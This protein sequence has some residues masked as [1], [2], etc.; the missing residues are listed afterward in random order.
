MRETKAVKRSWIET[1]AKLFL[2]F[3]LLSATPSLLTIQK[4]FANS[5]SAFSASKDLNS[6]TVM[7]FNVE[8]LFDTVHDTGK[9]DQTYLPLELKKRHPSSHAKNCSIFERED[10]K[11]ECLELDWNEKTF[12][13]KM[14]ALGEVILS[15]HNESGK[16]GPDILLL[17]E[18]ENLR[19]LNRLNTIVLKAASYRTSV[20]IEGKDRRGIDVAVLSRF[21]ISG[22]SRLHWVN[23]SGA[24]DALKQDTRGILQVD[25]EIAPKKILTV[26]ALHLPAPHHPTAARKQSIEYLNELLKSLPKG[27]M[28]IAGGDF[29]L[30]AQIPAEVELLSKNPDWLVSHV[31]GC[32]TCKGSIYY[33]PKKVWSFFDVLLFSK[34]LSQ[35]SGDGLFAV[36][37]P[38][39]SVVGGNSDGFPQ[40]FD[41]ASGK[42]ASDH[43]PVIATLKLRPQKAD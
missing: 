25:L 32:K 33:P 26:Y 23:H 27:R 40:K 9:Q 14:K 17:Q 20:L 37:A 34:N 7:T 42:G 28:A 3:A 38:S 36:D 22:K 12:E 39:I 2:L 30:P 5:A 43:L 29:N 31:I 10:W 13:A 19:A 16:K 8:N 21:P 11:K 35:E 24:S 15:V 18:V 1:S 4:A 41:P 6:F